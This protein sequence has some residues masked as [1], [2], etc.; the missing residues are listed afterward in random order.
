MASDE[1]Q[2]LIDNK[3][4]DLDKVCFGRLQK[5]V[6]T[7]TIAMTTNLILNLPDENLDART[8]LYLATVLNL[9]NSKAHENINVSE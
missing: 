5:S 6:A 8:K 9:F 4:A 1:E 3:V 7:C 2:K